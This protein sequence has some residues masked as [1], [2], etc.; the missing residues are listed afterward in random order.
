MFKHKYESPKI[1]Q[2]SVFLEESISTG[3]T[4]MSFGGDNSSFTPEVEDWEDSNES[5]SGGFQL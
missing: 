2:Y 5:S 4:N 3:S 1:L